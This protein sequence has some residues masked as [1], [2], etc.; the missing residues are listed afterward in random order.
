[1]R[2]L[3]AVLFPA[4]ASQ[5]DTNLRATST[6]NHEHRICAAEI[7]GRGFPGFWV[8]DPLAIHHEP[9]FVAAWRKGQ[10]RLP[11][12]SIPD[13]WRTLA[14]PVIKCPRNSYRTR[15]GHLEDKF[16][17][18]LLGFLRGTLR[19]PGWRSCK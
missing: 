3:N 9:I 17:G 15:I 5:K 18:F 10:A 19:C 13:H 11:A 16:H 7:V 12:S 8:A 6:S 14:I 2:I 4:G 1:M